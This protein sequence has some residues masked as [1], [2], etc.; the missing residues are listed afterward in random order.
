MTSAVFHKYNEVGL[1]VFTSIRVACA[2]YFT[3]TLTIIYKCFSGVKLFYSVYNTVF[4]TYIS[5]TYLKCTAIKLFD[6]SI[7]SHIQHYLQATKTFYVI[8]N[9]LCPLY[10]II[11]KMIDAYTSENKQVDKLTCFSVHTIITVLHAECS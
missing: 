1:N 11:C 6:V 5:N 7:K 3:C 8:L 10:V 4:Y 2:V 9:Y